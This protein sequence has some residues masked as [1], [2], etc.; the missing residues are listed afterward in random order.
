MAINLL[1]TALCTVSAAQQY[2]N[3][4]AEQRGRQFYKH[5]M[6]PLPVTSDR[7]SVRRSTTLIKWKEQVLHD[8]NNEECDA[9]GWIIVYLEI[10]MQTYR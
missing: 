7:P 5:C 8:R 2:C 6:P 9:P 3:I 1:K 4:I 10:H